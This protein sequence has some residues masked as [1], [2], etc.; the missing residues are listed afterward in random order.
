VPAPPLA[1]RTSG[2]LT[3]RL[4]KGWQRQADALHV[5]A[6]GPAGETL[7]TWSGQVWREPPGVRQGT[8]GA[9]PHTSRR[10]TTVRDE[11][12]A[13]IVTGAP[14]E[15][16]FDRR[17]GEV[18]SWRRGGQQAP[19][20]NGPAARAYVRRDRTHVAVPDTPELV[21]LT[22]RKEGKD[23]LVEAR[24]EGI[25]RRALWRVGAGDEDV[26]F[27]YE[28]SY[29]GDADLL[30]VGFGLPAEGL[31]SKRW[32]GRGP[33]RYRNRLEGGVFD[34]HQVAYNDPV[35][36][37]SFTYPEFRG[38]FYDWRWLQ[39]ET[40]GGSL[41]AENVSGVPFF[42]LCGPRDGEPPM[43]AFPDAGL[44]FLDVVPAQGTKFDTPDQLGPQS[45][46]P[47][48]H[49]ARRGTIVMRFTAK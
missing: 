49:G 46:T 7:W 6:R 43:M 5:T 39:L 37:Q 35:P 17:T 14:G 36:G 29:D 25:L 31:T 21:S 19:L 18:A 38:Y 8:A 47:A 48:V 22:W 42:G 16:R 10:E 23:V 30:G 3:I 27:D 33:Y 20:A 24:Y 1:P 34:L 2:S 9:L 11:K 32:L 45:R 41:T 15:L 12:D 40:A 4:P 44:A 28:Y 26:R 13:L